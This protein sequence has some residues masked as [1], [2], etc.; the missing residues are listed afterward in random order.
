MTRQEIETRI[1]HIREFAGDDETAHGLE[2]D[3]RRDFL[4]AIAS[5]E[6]DIRWDMAELAALVL[7]TDDIDFERWCA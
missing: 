2:D 6:I 4:K 5:G 3:L 7:T 1:E